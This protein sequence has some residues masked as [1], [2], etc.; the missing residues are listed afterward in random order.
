MTL[1]K[2]WN[3]LLYG[4]FFCTD[5]DKLLSTVIIGQQLNILSCEWFCILFVVLQFSKNK[6]GVIV[7][8]VSEE[9]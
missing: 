5:V 6:M 8:K 9:K 7:Q 4:Y 2:C 1:G 3:L